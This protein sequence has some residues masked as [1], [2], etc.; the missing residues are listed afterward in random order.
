MKHPIN[1]WTKKDIENWRKQTICKGTKISLFYTQQNLLSA[2]KKL[3]TLYTPRVNASF[4]EKILILS[5]LA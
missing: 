4:A 5:E 2:I 1:T 3:E